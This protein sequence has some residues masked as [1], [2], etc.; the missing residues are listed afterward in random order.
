M[1]NPTS[2]PRSARHREFDVDRRARGRRPRHS[3][4]AEPPQRCEFDLI[5][6]T[7]APEFNLCRVRAK[8]PGSASHS[9]APCGRNST[10][11]LG[12]A[13]PQLRMVGLWEAG[14]HATVDAALGLA[15]SLGQAGTSRVAIAGAVRPVDAHEL[16]G[17]QP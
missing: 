5:T 1:T 12:G 3:P 10:C 8:T 11:S 15:S 4:R 7:E 9:V 16:G 14:T 2:T 6:L 17:K 13:F